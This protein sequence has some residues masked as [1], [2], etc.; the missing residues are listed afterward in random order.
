M[1]WLLQRIANTFNYHCQPLSNQD[2]DYLRSR[3]DQ[4]FPNG[5]V[6]VDLSMIR[7]SQGKPVSVHD[8]YYAVVRWLL[9]LY[10]V[11]SDMI[12]MRY[13]SRIPR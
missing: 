11:L 4:V 9:L 3:M 2:I 13:K 1:F 5:V 10:Y 7:T 6:L 8:S 12:E